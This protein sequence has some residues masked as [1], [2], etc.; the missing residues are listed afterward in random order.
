MPPARMQTSF[1]VK[2]PALTE[3]FVDFTVKTDLRD[4]CIGV[5]TGSALILAKNS[6]SHLRIPH[7][8]VDGLTLL[9]AQ[10]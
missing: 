9:T 5:R 3:A 2:P 7:V 4:S 6:S 10:P 1:L 8:V